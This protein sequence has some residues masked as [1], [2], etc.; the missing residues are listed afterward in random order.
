MKNNFVKITI[1]VPYD[2]DKITTYYSKLIRPFFLV[3]TMT[4]FSLKNF[5][6]H[7]SDKTSNDFFSLKKCN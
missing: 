4:F 6:C 3:K 7:F 1:F 2:S 5:F